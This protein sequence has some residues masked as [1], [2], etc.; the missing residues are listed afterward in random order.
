MS[1]EDLMRLLQNDDS[2][3]FNEIYN[4]YR[5]PLYS[6]L[7]GLVNSTIA[8]E[9]MQETFIKILKKKNTFQFDSRLKTWIWAIAKNTLRD[10]WRSL[11]YKFYAMSEA[12]LRENNNEE[13][14]EERFSS[15]NPLPEEQFLNKVTKEQLIACIEEFPVEQ[16]ELL[17]LHIQSELSNQEIADMSNLS[18]GAVKSVLFRSKEKLINCFKKGGHL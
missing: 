6:Y 5:V 10:F 1:D 18:V 16:K 7:N 11:D 12:L 15:P 14:D 17:L 2:Q 9:L 3:A 8:E 13:S 4:R